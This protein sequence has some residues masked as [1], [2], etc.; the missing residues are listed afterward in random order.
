M[1]FRKNFT[2]GCVLALALVGAAAM[3]AHAEPIQLSGAA[4]IDTATGNGTGFGTVDSGH[5]VFMFHGLAKDLVSLTV[6][7][8][9]VLP[10][11]FND[12]DS[13]LFLFDN[14][15]RLL[16][17]NDDFQGSRQS[18]I[19]G[20]TLPATG[21]YFVGVTSFPNDALPG[22]VGDVITGWEDNG[23]S[24]FTFNL[25]IDRQAI[26]G[27]GGPQGAPEP[28]GLL[29]LSCGGLCLGIHRWRQRRGQG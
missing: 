3:R 16:A 8:T 23:Q 25:H 5:Q 9:Q 13:K 12:D 28:T 10:S 20:F 15:G 2:A 27:A 24:A 6:E 22:T 11:P 1:I 26:Q 14:D 21:T 19:E 7:V 4:M 18:R 29:L 17:L